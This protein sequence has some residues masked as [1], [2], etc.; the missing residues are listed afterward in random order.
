MRTDTDAGRGRAGPTLADLAA[1]LD[2]VLA[3]QH[4]LRR[5]VH[6]M[7]VPVSVLTTAQAAERIGRSERVLCTITARGVFTDGRS[8]QN[9][10]KGAP[11]LYYADELDVYRSEGEAGVRRLR[12]ALGRD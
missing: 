8:P 7:T 5:L 3:E 2:A 10:V 4:E 12:A 9:R 11:R 6:R 1:K